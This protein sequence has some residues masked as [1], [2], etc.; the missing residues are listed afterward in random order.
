M[1]QYLIIGNSAG[2]IGA[3]EAIR[4]ADPTG[5]LC[6]VSE[7]ALPA[8]SRPQIAG[9]LAGEVGLE[10]ALFRPRDF[11][12]KNNIR[13]LLNRQVVELDRARQVA[14]CA[15][16]RELAYDRLL[17]ATGGAPIVPPTKGLEATG[18]TTFATM[19]D[20]RKLRDMLPQLKQVVVVGGGL[21]GLS[22]AEA[23]VKAGVRVVVV[24]LAPQILGRALDGAAA[25]LVQGIMEAQNVRILTGCSVAEVRPGESAA[26]GIAILSS[27]VRVEYDALLMAI[28][29][30]PRVELAVRAGLK[31]NR[32]IVVD[33]QM[34]TDDPRIYACGDAAEAYDY[35]AGDA[36]L[37]PIWPNAYLGGRVAGANMAGGAAAYPGGT[38][39]NAL[40]FFGYP[41]LSAG[42]A[43]PGPDDGCQVLAEQSADG[44]AYKKIVLR[45]GKVVGF[46]FAGEIDRAGVVH[47]LMRDR[48]D[49]TPFIDKLFAAEGA[50]IA[51]PAPLRRAFY[52]QRGVA[53]DL[54]IRRERPHAH[55]SSV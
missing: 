48:A 30:R 2:S 11:Y 23:L 53:R 54:A 52:A 4:Q 9:Y 5:E 24:E 49:V 33:A 31:V 29:V 45:D 46:L 43:A 35:I 38:G 22:A 55:E 18:Y 50:F 10:Q 14:V 7:E 39:M 44:R 51:L 1:T 28:G 36:R 12:A 19:D 3:A 26:A 27:G 37:T 21:I 13:L 34:R 16:G 32:G 6:I 17:L 40:H 15:D 8:Y 42:L 47:G 25:A 41:I 20:A